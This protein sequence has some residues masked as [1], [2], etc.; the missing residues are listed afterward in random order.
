MRMRAPLAVLLLCVLALGALAQSPEQD[1]WT[2]IDRVVAVGD[3]HGDFQQFTALLRSA[4]L[5][6]GKNNWSG[7][8]AHLVQTGDLLDRGPDSRRCIDFIVKLTDQARRAGGMVHE[9][10]GN[11]EAM[12]L[13]GDLRYVPPEEF[14][15]FRDGDSE[16]RRAAYYEQFVEQMKKSPPPGGLPKFDAEYQRQWFGKTPLGFVERQI[17][18]GPRGQ[19]G[20]WFRSRNAV[21]KVNDSVFLHGGIGPKYAAVPL[22]EINERIRSE[23][24]DFSKLEKGITMDTDG[25]LWYRGLAQDPEAAMGEHVDRVLQFHG[26]HRI[27][28]GHTVLDGTVIPRFGAKVLAIDAGM[29]ALYGSRLACLVLEGGSAYTLHRGRKIPVPQDSG[30]ALLE[31]LRACAAADP[32][33]SP[34]AKRIVELES[35][36]GSPRE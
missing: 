23:L 3:V 27:V 21:V 8:R 4:E 11:H 36:V 10:L 22:H 5:I 35:S 20:K 14:A 7:G 13:Y 19:Y 29:S 1:V 31:Y 33:P 6:D 12:N 25:P 2:G 15:S 16:A 18:F 34:L 17:Q 24:A 30:R 9:L 26:V 32:P 28:I